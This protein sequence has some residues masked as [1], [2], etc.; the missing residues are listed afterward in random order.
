MTMKHLV[1]V[2]GTRPELIK[3]APVIREAQRHPELQ[4]TIINTGQ[5]RE[6]MEPLWELFDCQYDIKLDI[7]QPGQSLASLTARAINGLEETLCKLIDEKSL[8]E[9]NAV[10]MAQGDTTTVM[11]AA[12]C[13]F[14]R[15]I[16][17]AHIEAGLR[18]FDLD[19]P[20]PEEFNRRVASIVTHYHFTPTARSTENLKK[21]H[22]PNCHIHQVGNTVVD[23]LTMVQSA[24]NFHTRPFNEAQLN[25]LAPSKKSL[26]LITCHRR[27]NHGSGVTE[28]IQAIDFL[29]HN[30]PDLTFIWPVHLNP[31]VY[32]PVH[33]SILK[34]RQNVL[35]TKPLDYIDLLKVISLSKIILSD[36]GGIQEEAPSFGVPVLILREI[37]ERPEAVEA[38]L[39]KL[40]GCTYDNILNGF[41]I[42]KDFETQSSNPYGDGTAARQICEALTTPKPER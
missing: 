22:V 9:E 17:F 3:L 27:E 30:H 21:E 4:A 40:V 29:A 5:H 33:K 39:S 41:S 28:L 37:T 11:A 8:S 18:S 12:M 1:I 20:F 42:Y 2:I 15:Q 19:H 23:A 31:N 35:L 7:I 24:D 16:P 13:A 25:T 10:I 32:Q 34:S 26:V 36:S 14:Y 6:L 38:G